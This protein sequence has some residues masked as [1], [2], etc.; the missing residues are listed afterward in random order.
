[1][2]QMINLDEL[3]ERANRYSKTLEA[4]AWPKYTD[5]SEMPDPARNID[6]SAIASWEKDRH[7]PDATHKALGPLPQFS[8]GKGYLGGKEATPESSSFEADRRKVEAVV[9]GN[10][11]VDD[12][13][14]A[15][16]M[17]ASMEPDAPSNPVFQ[18]DAQYKGSD[19][20]TGIPGT[21]A[22][23]PSAGGI[24]RETEYRF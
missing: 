16:R 15:L 5:P 9:H 6:Y 24:T 7:Y 3:V 23:Y 20:M 12:L 21:V 11:T 19:A 8:L 10:A 17:M 2:G 14:A 1:M 4:P 22:Q 13:L 18:L